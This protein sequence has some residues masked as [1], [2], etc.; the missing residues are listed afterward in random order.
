MFLKRFNFSIWRTKP[1]HV[2]NFIL[3]WLIKLVWEPFSLK[4]SHWWHWQIKPLPEGS[5]PIVVKGDSNEKE[6]ATKWLNFSLT[7]FGWQKVVLLGTYKVVSSDKAVNQQGDKMCY[8]DITCKSYQIGWNQKS[9]SKFKANEFEVC[10]IV[11]NGIIGLLVGPGETNFYAH[12][13]SGAPLDLSVYAFTTKSE[14][15]RKGFQVF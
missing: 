2:F 1:I 11:Q 6:R 7:N 8:F 13:L 15:V 4:R 12:D 9:N 5:K 14:A 3:W 10:T